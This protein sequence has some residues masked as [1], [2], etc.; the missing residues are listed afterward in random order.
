MAAASA[1]RVRA[2][3][4]GAS[5]VDLAAAVLAPIAVL[6][7]VTDTPWWLLGG[8]ATALVFIVA[9]SRRYPRTAVLAAFPLAMWSPG[10]G[11]VAGLAGF[12]AGRQ[13]TRAFPRMAAAGAAVTAAGLVLSWT[14]RSLAL[15]SVV[16]APLFVV[17][18]WA[19]GHYRRQLQEL[20]S[21]E[22]HGLI[23]RERQRERERIA[24]D[25]HDSLGHEIGLMALRAGALEVSP[26]LEDREVREAAG[27][28]RAGAA[29]A[30]ERLREVIGVLRPGSDTDGPSASRMSVSR[31]V[32]RANDSGMPVTLRL[33]GETTAAPDVVER[34]VRRIVQEGLTNAAKH[35]AGMPVEVRVE[36]AETETAVAVT[37]RV[38]SDDRSPES[39]GDGL[40]LAGLRERVRLAG[41]TFSAAPLDGGFEVGAR[42]PHAAAARQVEETAVE[43]CGD[44]LPP[45]LAQ[46]ARRRLRRDFVLTMVALAACA[47][48]AGTLTAYYGW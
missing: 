8:A 14:G 28:L 36:R 35:A 45:H 44:P 12:R 15:D 7:R 6:N 22:R 19:A 39:T 31:I 32:E 29:A 5:R 24:H 10:A 40:G 3:A 48:T 9:L 20:R 4:R 33:T 23:E 34:A 26:R 38:P 18:P 16:F 37:N 2:A 42:L 1:P 41:G 17:L 13:G 47:V 11:I 21:R 25:M 46:D 43:S 27:E 30:A